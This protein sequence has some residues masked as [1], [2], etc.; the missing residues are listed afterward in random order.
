M[1][2]GIRD[3]SGR[4]ETGQAALVTLSLDAHDPVLTS[5]MIL[6]R[7]EIDLCDVDLPPRIYHAAKGLAQDA[8]QALVEH[9]G[10]SAARLA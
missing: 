8:A 6:D 7:R 9:V 3:L 5:A 2:L 4:D 10:R 1:A